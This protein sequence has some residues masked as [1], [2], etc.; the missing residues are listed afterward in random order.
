MRTF[1]I[2][3]FLIA[4]LGTQSLHAMSMAP[5]SMR[6]KE[7]LCAVA[8]KQRIDERARRRALREREKQLVDGLLASHADLNANTG[9]GRPLELVMRVKAIATL[10]QNGAAPA[11]CQRSTLLQSLF[12]YM[13]RTDEELPELF[14]KREK[15]YAKKRE[16]HIRRA[17]KLWECFELL[18]KA[19]ADANQ[20]MERKLILQRMIHLDHYDYFTYI[21]LD[22]F[23]KLLIWHGADPEKVETQNGRSAYNYAAGV[24]SFHRLNYIKQERGKYEAVC[25]IL[26]GHKEE[27]SPFSRLPLEMVYKIIGYVK[28]GSFEPPVEKRVLPPKAE[29]PTSMSTDRAPKEEESKKGEHEQPE[30]L[31]EIQKANREVLATDVSLPSQPNPVRISRWRHMIGKKLFLAAAVTGVGWWAYTRWKKHKKEQEKKRQ[32]LWDEYYRQRSW[33]AESLT[34]QLR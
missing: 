14:W 30:P 1:H 23:F 6:P 20:E 7:P 13:Y 25:Q 3:F 31:K 5:M 12:Y 24:G 15:Y 32:E 34:K 19:G 9:F 18:L 8:E 28:R 10:L 27:G 29:T 16:E 33:C 4:F 17:T 26:R 11:Q 22:N 2:L 21:N